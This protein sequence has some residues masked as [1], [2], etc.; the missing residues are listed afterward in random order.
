MTQCKDILINKATF[1]AYP[2]LLEMSNDKISVFWA[3]LTQTSP[4][5]S[6]DLI[7]TKTLNID[8][9]FEN[10]GKNVTVYNGFHRDD[11][12]S[13]KLD[14]GKVVLAYFYWKANVPNSG[15]KVSILSSS[16]TPIVYEFPTDSLT[17]A[18]PSVATSS[19]NKFMVVWE[20][21]ESTPHRP[22]GAIFNDAGVKQVNDFDFASGTTYF[23]DN[24]KSY[25]A[26]SGDGFVIGWV[27]QD[28][29]NSN[30]KG[31]H[32]RGY[33]ADGT[34]SFARNLIVQDQFGAPI[35]TKLSS[36]DC[37][38][39]T[40][41]GSDLSAN[42]IIFQKFSCSTGAKIGSA[43]NVDDPVYKTGSFITKMSA[44]K[45]T[46]SVFWL[47]LFPGDKF[48]KVLYG[49]DYNNDGTPI[50]SKYAISNDT[51]STYG[52]DDFSCIVTQADDKVCAF[53]YIGTVSVHGLYGQIIKKNG[54][55][56]DVP[57]P[58]TQPPITQEPTSKPSNSSQSM[59][60][61]ATSLFAGSFYGQ[62]SELFSEIG[63][64]GVN[65]VYDAYNSLSS[66]IDFDYLG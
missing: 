37:V 33:N 24:K 23:G 59:V 46:F 5:T 18:H 22:Y 44:G 54:E 39:L 45:D 17:G 4:T 25:V 20:N 49:R 40:S 56:V 21:K 14:N 2:S 28:E 8:G 57:E 50:N 36:G 16:L 52:V 63:G 30:N 7:Y 35:I 13:A 66:L 3:R 26:S 51:T 48:R 53:Y 34:Q 61:S 10:N 60:S 32:V 38:G 43:V 58:T 42:Q 6:E 11:I 65:Y 62:I 1:D 9:S 55:C 12:T 64:Q 27:G 47:D 41:K 29:S 19:S 31:L 15:I